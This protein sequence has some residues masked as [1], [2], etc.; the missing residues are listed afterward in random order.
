[1]QMLNLLEVIVQFLKW[2]FSGCKISIICKGLRFWLRIYGS[3]QI[4]DL[5]EKEHRTEGL[6][7]L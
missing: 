7:V 5:K 4:I 3:E 1:M 6:H 2:S